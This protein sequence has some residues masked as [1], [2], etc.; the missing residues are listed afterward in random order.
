[1]SEQSSIFD[2]SFDS[3]EIPRR[4]E[5]MPTWL[6][7]YTWFTVLIGILVFV[8]G[9][10]F[11]PD[12]DPNEIKDAA[13]WIGS[14]I[15]KGLVAAIYL[16]PGLLVWFEAKYAIR[17]N[18]IMAA[19]WGVTVLLAAALTQWSNLIF[20]MTMIFFIPFWAGLLFIRRKWIKEAVS[21]RTL[22]RKAL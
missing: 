4:R 14:F 6:K 13:Y 22:R 20:G 7:V 8:Y 15:G 18:L 16:V 10:F 9:F 3:T 2:E 1:M 17:F 19:I 12:D 5:L 21:G 11:A